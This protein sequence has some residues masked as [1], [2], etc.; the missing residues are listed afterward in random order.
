MRRDQALIAAVEHNDARAVATLLAQGADPNARKPLQNGVPWWRLIIAQM[1]LRRSSASARETALDIAVRADLNTMRPGGLSIIQSLI[2]SGALHRPD[3]AANPSLA[4]A[5]RPLQGVPDGPM[6]GTPDRPLVP[7]NYDDF[8]EGDWDDASNVQ[9]AHDAFYDIVR[10]YGASDRAYA[11]LA[12]CLLRAHQYEQA[13]HAFRLA[14]LWSPRSVSA[15]AGLL[16]AGRLNQISAAVSATLRAPGMEVL[17]VRP[18]PPENGVPRWMVLYAN[19]RVDGPADEGITE[20]RVA[21][22]AGAG[23]TLSRIWQSSALVGP[24]AGK[25]AFREI[26][27]T[28]WNR[29]GSAIPDVIVHGTYFGTQGFWDPADMEIFAYHRGGFQRILDVGSSEPLWLEDIDHDGRYEIL[30]FTEFGTE[31][32]HVDQPRIR[33]AGYRFHL[34]NWR[35]P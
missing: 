23:S 1:H 32:S 31:L 27:M 9:E 10:K 13:A 19:K 25:G 34:E 17:C 12:A 29:K 16:S 30:N 24:D 15:Q 33:Q 20:A 8:G 28:T 7:V 6:R 26:T 5:E 4:W 21:C 3:A 22:Y 11:G 18:F 14:L 35:E 2:N